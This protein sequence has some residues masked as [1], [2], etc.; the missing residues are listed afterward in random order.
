[1][2]P[3]IGAGHSSGYG[4][5]AT[6]SCESVVALAPAPNRLMEVG[7]ST[8]ATLLKPLSQNSRLSSPVPAG[9]SEHAGTSISIIDAAGLG[10]AVQRSSC[11][12]SSGPVKTHVEAS[13]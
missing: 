8:K 7:L 4:C 5:S 10:L 6:R 3:S 2:V 13:V 1:M 9:S 12:R 11:S